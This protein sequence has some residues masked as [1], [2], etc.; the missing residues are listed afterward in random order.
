MEQGEIEG[1]GWGYRVEGRVWGRGRGYRGYGDG[2]EVEGMG[3][4]VE[5]G[6]VEGGR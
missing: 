6:G 2:G 3:W 4:G 1:V 5:G